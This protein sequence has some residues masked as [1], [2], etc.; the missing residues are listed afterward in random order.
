V[1]IDFH[2]LANIFPLVDGDEFNGLVEDIRVHGVREPIWIYDGEILDGRNRYRASEVAGVDCPM[3]EYLG[4]DPAAFVV[5]LNL[6]R[7]HLTE[8][9]RGMVAAKLANLPAHRPTEDNC[10]NLRTSQD[11]AAEM[12]NVSRRTVQTAKHV[13]EQGAPELIQAVESGQVSV[14]AAAD[15]ATLPKKEQAEIVARGEKEILQAAKAIRAE[16]VETKRAEKIAQTQVIAANNAALPVGERKYSVIYADPPW[17][18]DVW[19]GA[20]KDRAAENHYPTMTQAE[21]EALPVEHMAADDCALFMWAVMPQLPEAL[22]VIKA[23]G[24]EY[25]T[26]AFVWVKQTKD[27]ERFATGMGYWTRANAEICLLA[28]RGSPARL[29]ADVHQVIATPRMEHSKKPADAAERIERLVPG[30]YLEMFARSPRDGWD[31]WGNQ[32]EAAA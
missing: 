5:S 19:S 10:A 16:K 14:S 32:A 9:Q 11:A 29:N 13:Q 24:F 18:F 27:E 30:P 17:S 12:L 8:S 23:W 4:D 15:V 3:R 7:R 20:G 21:I 22:A 2:P 1:S 28:T 25:K 6:K 31:V 26:C